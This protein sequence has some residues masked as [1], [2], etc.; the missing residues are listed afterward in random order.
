MGMF[1]YIK[2]E[3]KLPLISDLGETSEVN[4]NELTY[5]TKDMNDNMDNYTIRKNGTLWIQKYD[6]EWI[7]GNPKAKSVCDRIGHAV[8]KRK[9]HERIKDFTGTIDFYQI[10][11]LETL[12]NT[13]KN[14]YWIEFRATFVKGKMKSIVLLKFEAIPNDERKRSEREHL[15]QIKAYTQFINRWYIRYTYVPYRNIIMW[16]FRQ[17]RKL[18]YNLPPSYKIEKFLLPW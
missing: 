14:D 15:A 16:I 10:P 13:W 1:D 7:P 5:Q 12:R 9:W 18:T 4:Y 2:C 8:I 6:A 11:G 17:W 3:A